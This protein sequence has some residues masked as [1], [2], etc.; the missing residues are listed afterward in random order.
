MLLSRRIS[1]LLVAVAMAVLLT[2]GTA[3][4]HGGKRHTV[5]HVKKGPDV[6]LRGLTHKQAQWHINNHPNDYWGRCG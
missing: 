2:M 3:L 1:V 5:C 6:T 4:A